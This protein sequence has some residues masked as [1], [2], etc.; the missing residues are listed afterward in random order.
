[1]LRFL[2][3]VRSTLT[4]RTMTTPHAGQRNLTAYNVWGV[5]VNN[6]IVILRS[7]VHKPQELSEPMELSSLDSEGYQKA[8]VGAI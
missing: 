3:C 1:M 7:P 2:F 8:P 6:P 5:A 4:L